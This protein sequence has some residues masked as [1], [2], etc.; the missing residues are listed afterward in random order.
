MK[1][2][3]ASTHKSVVDV[4]VSILKGNP[5]DPEA[6]E[7]HT[8]YFHELYAALLILQLFSDAE[9]LKSYLCQYYVDMDKTSV[10]DFTEFYENA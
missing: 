8:K 2:T 7:I 1:V 3:L 9:K 5:L 10:Q 4:V 6:L